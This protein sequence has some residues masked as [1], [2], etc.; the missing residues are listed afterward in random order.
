MCDRI[1]Y[2]TPVKDPRGRV[3]GFTESRNPT[4]R[5]VEIAPGLPGTVPQLLHLNFWPNALSQPNAQNPLGI[6]DEVTHALSVL[7]RPP[8]AKIMRIRPLVN[9]RFRIWN[10]SL[11]IPGLTQ[12]QR[13]QFRGILSAET[14]AAN[15][16]PPSGPIANELRS[17]LLLELRPNVDPCYVIGAL[18]AFRSVKVVEVVPALYGPQRNE[19]IDVPVVPSSIA[20]QVGED[21]L[22]DWMHEMTARPTAWDTV[23]QG[24]AA[25]LA[26][27]D[28]GALLDHPSLK[29]AIETPN[30]NW[31]RP[32]IKDVYGHGTHIASQIV[33]RPVTG[34][35][36]QYLPHGVL[37]AAKALCFNIFVTE[38]SN[39]HFGLDI[40][41]FYT[42]LF[43]IRLKHPVGVVNM[44][45]WMK[46]EPSETLLE[47]FTALDDK[48]I[49]LVACAGNHFADLPSNQPLAQDSAYRVLY[50]ARLPK[51]LSVGA[52]DG[53]SR[54]AV[55]SRFS[56]WRTTGRD[57]N[58]FYGKEAKA[59]KGWPL[60]DIVAPGVKVWGAAA[61]AAAFPNAS[62]PITKPATDPANNYGAIYLRGTSMA[63]PYVTAGI[64]AIKHLHTNWATASAEE[65]RKLVRLS[66]DKADIPAPTTAD[67]WT[68]EELYGSGLL[69]YQALATAADPLGTSVTGGGNG[70]GG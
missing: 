70:S 43:T 11:A 25:N 66:V 67:E 28:S 26:I 7:S 32:S 1:P 17:R 15:V 4:N 39:N 54:R 6:P 61:K 40:S 16:A 35:L 59:L 14:L 58:D 53:L 36:G 22:P 69:D 33:G 3:T 21:Y 65:V 19:V 60:V 57:G 38:P 51:I 34:E 20:K 56:T 18:S 10:S 63:A 2:I 44:S 9:T 23:G 31:F 48:G 64:A 50:P 47:E 13:E 37:P 41:A 68:S 5:N 49:V 24:K 12:A 46:Y 55:F 62:L 29:D 42:A 45:I 52:I 8:G 27:L 30:S